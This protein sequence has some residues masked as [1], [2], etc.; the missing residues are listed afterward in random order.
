VW[1][2]L[3]VLL[4][5]LS[6]RLLEDAAGWKPLVER[7]L[8]VTGWAGLELAL[9]GTLGARP[10][11]T[12]LFGLPFAAA[13]PALRIMMWVVPV[14]WMSGH[15]RYSLI[16]AGH[17]RREYHAGLVGAVATI[18]LSVLLAPAF[19]SVGTALALLGGTIANAVVAVW[20]S[21]GVLPDLS[22]RNSSSTS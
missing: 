9:V 2:Y 14:A 19:R 6:R 3:Y 17:A 16:A 5:V 12:T 18:L 7:S 21:R 20:L 1:L 15:V 11:L 4:P 13:V 22:F 8:R 10:I